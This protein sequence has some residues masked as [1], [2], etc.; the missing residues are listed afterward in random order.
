M[1]LEQKAK[2]QLISI[3]F[4][5]DYLETSAK[6]LRTKGGS[7]LAEEL[8]RQAYYWDVQAQALEELLGY[9]L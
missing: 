7:D 5:I 6:E 8:D 3:L 9:Y 4:H 1:S 2:Q